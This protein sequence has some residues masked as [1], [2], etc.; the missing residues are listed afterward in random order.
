MCTEVQQHSRCTIYKNLYSAGR[1]HLEK[2]SEVSN[3]DL[4]RQ[5]VT[6]DNIYTFHFTYV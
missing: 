5:V 2:V 4:L 1:N 3:T 6:P